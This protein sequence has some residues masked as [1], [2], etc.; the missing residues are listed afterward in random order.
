MSLNINLSDID[1]AELDFNNM[2][3]WPKAGKVGLALVV[4][5]AVML[6]SYLFLIKDQVSHLDAQL[7]KEQELRLEYQS[8]YG[9]AINLEPV[10]YTH[11]TL[12]TKA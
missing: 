1:L 5:S 3:A 9:K 4:A 8:K 10:S 6:L 11:L 12:P 7:Q 2:G